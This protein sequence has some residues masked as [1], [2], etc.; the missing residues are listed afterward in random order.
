MEK[1]LNEETF[2]D[3]EE[4][5]AYVEVGRPLTRSC[6]NKKQSGKSSTSHPESVRLTCPSPE[7]RGSEGQDAR[8]QNKPSSSGSVVSNRG[9]NISGFESSHFRP[10]LEERG[11]NFSHMTTL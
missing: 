9:R 4:L 7:G 2:P 5:N 11:E 8:I 3:E 1:Y 6:T 10:E